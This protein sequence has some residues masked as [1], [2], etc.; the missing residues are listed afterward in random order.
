M[1]RRLGLRGPALVGV[2]L[3]GG[4]YSGEKEIADFISLSY[5][6]SSAIK[7]E[8][9]AVQYSTAELKE[10]FEALRPYASLRLPSVT[11][12]A[13]GGVPGP[14][15]DDRGRPEEGVDSP[16]ES[17]GEGVTEMGVLLDR[18]EEAVARIESSTSTILQEVHRVEGAVPDVQAA[19]TMVEDERGKL[20]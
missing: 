16:S 3:L 20:D 7:E 13:G 14:G 12:P 19:L 9:N 5:Q 4:C 11:P 6:S 17:E 2:L 15:A 8:A 10:I 18:G 1:V